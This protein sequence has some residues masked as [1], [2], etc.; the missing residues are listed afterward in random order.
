MRDFIIEDSEHVSLC[1]ALDR[2]LNKGAVVIG[3]VT[4]SVAN[5][6][7]VYLGLQAVLTSIETA[8]RI[9]SDSDNPPPIR[10]GLGAGA[11]LET[12]S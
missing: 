3:E 2:I 10:L 1:E 11:G 7:L 12:R 6:D 8:Q 5:I 4:I 9:A